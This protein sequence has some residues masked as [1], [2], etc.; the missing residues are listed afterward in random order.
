MVFTSFEFFVFF[1]FVF[2][3]YWLLLK[4]IQK[5]QNIFLLGASY[6]FYGWWDWK[7]LSLLL[8]I[9]AANWIT[10][11]LTGRTEA[12]R[13][14][15]LI[16]LAG[17]AVN[18]GTLL[19]FKYFNF[20][21]Q[22]FVLMGSLIGLHPHPATLKIILPAGISFYIFLSISYIVDVYRRKLV[23]E[24]NLINALLTFSFFPIIMS[25]PLERPISLL[26]QIRKERVFDYDLAADGIRQFIWGLFM[27]MVIANNAAVF[28]DQ[29]FNNIGPMSGGTLLLGALFFAIQI[30]ADFSGY[31][32]MAIG[33]GKLLG[34]KILRNFA[35]PYFAPD[36]SEF[37]K[38]WNISLTT[39]FRDYIFLPLAYYISD[40][41]KA[42]RFL[43]MK[44][45]LFIYIAGITVTWSLTGL[46]HGARYTFIAWGLI[47]GSA[48]I[49]YHI[50]RKPKQKLF[51]RIHNIPAGLLQVLEYFITMLVVL[52]AWIFF[53][54]ESIHQATVFL[55]KIVNPSLFLPLNQLP[56]I[57][58]IVSVVVAF[59]VEF[60]QRKRDY[61]LQIDSKIH[62]GIRW[63]SYYTVVLSIVFFG[64]GQQ[65][66]LYFQF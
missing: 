28:V 14:R 57:E 42:E 56:G 33:I 8:F 20:F 18:I 7:L 62:W 44:T 40:R 6:F 3:I 22:E 4:K 66:F 2:L 30:Y 11:I 37:W 39:W 13:K 12:K 29:I 32:D 49:V 55:S 15:K 46:W 63:L 10:A 5:G 38:R 24:K 27:K 47:H 17:L 21:I 51:R 58:L 54:S 64:G 9:S 50:V 36:I 61:P 52:A 45:E 16:L 53:R 48:L 43:L 25:G 31:S 23:P 34:F 65:Q 1:V 60:A 41:I 19:I 35:F 26:P 59:L